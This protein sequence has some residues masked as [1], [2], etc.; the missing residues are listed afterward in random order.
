ML[1]E[2][3]QN[4]ANAAQFGAEHLDYMRSL[5]KSGKVIYAGPMEDKHSAAILFATKEWSEVEQMLAKEPFH[6]EHVLKI[7]SHSV[8][9]ACETAKSAP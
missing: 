1:S 9:N 6:R 5:M 3:A 7:V 8:W 4:A 2:F